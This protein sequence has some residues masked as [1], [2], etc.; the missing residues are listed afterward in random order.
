MPPSYLNSTRLSSSRSSRRVILSPAL[1]KASSRILVFRT[2]QEKT[3]SSKISESGLKV[4][5][6]PCLSLG[7]GVPVRTRGPRGTPRA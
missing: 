7:S 4:M 5:R 6:V 3:V 1:R 2:S